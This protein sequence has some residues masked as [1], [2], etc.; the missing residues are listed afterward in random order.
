MNQ[1]SRKFICMSDIK[2][3]YGELN[4]V[5]YNPNLIGEKRK[6]N[7]KQTLKVY[8]GIDVSDTVIDHACSFEEENLDECI[9]YIK[10]AIYENT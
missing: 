4:P 2:P 10:H 7:L 9:D 5:I 1:N 3:V 6:S 8:M